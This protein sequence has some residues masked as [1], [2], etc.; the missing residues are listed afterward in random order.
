MDELKKS[1]EKIITVGRNKN[2]II[3]CDLSKEIPKIIT[4]KNFELVIH[5]AGKAHSNKNDKKYFEVNLQ[6]TINL[7]E[8]LNKTEKP[9]KFI[10]ISTVAVYGLDYG[11]NIDENTTLLSLNN[12]GKSKIEAEKLIEEWCIRNNVICT[13]LRLPLIIGKNPPGNL[14]SM[15]KGIKKKYYFNIGGGG[16]KKSMVLANDVAKFLTKI[17]SIGG[18]YNLTDGYHPSFYELSLSIGRKKALNLPLF[19][20]KTIGKIGDLLGENAP[21]NSD[22]LKK[23][24]NDLTFD[25]SKARKYGCQPQNVLDFLKN[26]EL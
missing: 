18:I 22:K 2:A 3:N 24:T 25:D 19:I 6:G 17:S 9:K 5:N 26:N 8:G 1:N 14:G 10:F 12:Y 23:I 11:K 21:I 13:I 20:A 4:D 7:L 15:I 16:A